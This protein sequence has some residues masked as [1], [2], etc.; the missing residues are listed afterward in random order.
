MEKILTAEA[1]GAPDTYATDPLL[2]SLDQLIA[3]LRADE[4]TREE[5]F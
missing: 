4:L 5:Y 3:E 2:R 1:R